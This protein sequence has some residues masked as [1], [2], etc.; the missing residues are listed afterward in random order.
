M[1][2]ISSLE[3]KS[4]VCISRIKAPPVCNEHLKK[5]SLNAAQLLKF[6]FAPN[7]D[8]NPGRLPSLSNNETEASWESVR[9]QILNCE[10]SR[11]GRQNQRFAS[12]SQTGKY[13]RLTT[14]TVP[15][16]NDGRILLC[17]SSR[18]D[19]WILPKGGWE[20]DETLE[21]SALRE[22]FEE[23]GVLGTL[24]PKLNQI[25]YETRK[26]KKRRLK[27]E[28]ERKQ[29][30]GKRS[31]ISSVVSAGSSCGVSSEDEHNSAK[32][33]S[34]EV[35][36]ESVAVSAPLTDGNS[37]IP[38]EKSD[39]TV[40]VASVTSMASDMP[41]TCTNCR[42]FMS[43]LYVCEAKDQWPESGRAR[44]LVDIDEAIK[45]MSERP[46][47]KAVLVEVKKKGY[48]LVGG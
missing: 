3:P 19:A 21:L 1:S 22:T 32:A 20:N 5:E 31:V 12:D 15:I 28:E 4:E 48:H 47:F 46:E 34:S 23:S 38:A 36:T 40:S 26:G 14:G 37:S 10:I 42:M 45:M 30:Q 43:I 44:K 41:S 35:C 7:D 18:K 13:F 29:K 25:E 2:P 9:R 11:N 24:G 16:M 17:S 8:S 39:D 6:C 27:M 33:P